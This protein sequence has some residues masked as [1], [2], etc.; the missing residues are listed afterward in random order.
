MKKIIASLLCLLVLGVSGA[1]L[2]AQGVNDIKIAREQTITDVNQCQDLNSEFEKKHFVR[3]KIINLIDYR[4]LNEKSVR[5]IN[6]QSR[7]FWDTWEIKNFKKDSYK[8]TYPNSPLRV[9]YYEEGE[10]EM[11]IN[12]SVGVSFTASTGISTSL[13]EAKL[14]FSINNSYSIT[15]SQKIDVPKGM[16]GKITAYT[17]YEQWRMDIYKNGEYEGEEFIHKPIGVSFTVDIFKK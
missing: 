7:I 15:D 17:L 5:P 12:Q 11:S 9:S 13:V 14:G 3:R 4:L 1:Y 10:G 6:A 2:S 16:R 8:I